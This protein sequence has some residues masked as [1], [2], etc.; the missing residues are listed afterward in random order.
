MNYP[1][2]IFLIDDDEDDGYIFDMAL[3][4]LSS[5]FELLYYQDSQTALS[6]LSEKAFP[7]PDMLFID[8]NMPKVDGNQCLQL[9]RKIP[10]YATVPIII[11]S[12]SK[13]EELQAEVLKLGASYFFAKPPTVKDL[14]EKL[15]NLL[16]KE[17]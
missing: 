11:Y 13:H 12:T 15:K 9:I 14:S 5:Q 6:K 4:G 8:W 17:W 2:R 10:G 1:N 7:P 16:N 3:N